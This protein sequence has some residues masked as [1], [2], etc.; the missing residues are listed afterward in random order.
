MLTCACH[1]EAEAELPQEV[2]WIISC[3]SLVNLSFLHLFSIQIQNS[4]F[5]VLFPILVVRMAAE[6]IA[7]LALSSVSVA[8]LFKTC[9]EC[10]SLVVAAQDFG[11][12]YEL[13]CTELSLQKVR[14]FLWGESV[15]LAS[16]ESDGKPRPNP[17]LDDSHI[18]PT[19][20][21]TLNAIKHLLSETQEFDE[22]Y[23]YKTEDTS[24]GSE[25]RG[26]SIFKGTFD[27][28]KNQTQ[29]NQKQKSIKTVTRWAIFDAE[30][31][32]VKITRLRQFVD[33][34]ESITVSLVALESQRDRLRQEI[35]SISDVESLRLLRDFSDS[36]FDD[37]SDTASR[38]LTYIESSTDTDT[39]SVIQ[40][41]ETSSTIGTFVTARSHWTMEIVPEEE[42]TGSQQEW[43]EL[44]KALPSIPEIPA[45]GSALPTRLGSASPTGSF[46]PLNW[47]KSGSTVKQSKSTTTASKTSS[48]HNRKKKIIYRIV[49]LG[50]DG[51]GKTEMAMQV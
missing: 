12:D 19:V 42:K 29:R 26:L 1:F 25:S 9:I 50:D 35:E 16:R 30:H 37:V 32:E 8:A 24:S 36:E 49:V 28:F 45:I 38:R 18:Q 10:Y 14:F 21:R 3:Y 39:M 15:G 27:Q 22:R 4:F 48:Q 20:V 2:R 34:L 44:D 33:G 6:G 23:G 5:L 51:V 7:G 13:L 47:N 41:T 31:F 43:P 17:G 11:Q 40:R 46:N